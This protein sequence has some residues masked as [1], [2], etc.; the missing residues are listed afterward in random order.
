MFTVT[1]SPAPG[2]VGEVIGVPMIG[3]DDGG[4]ATVAIAGR[5]SKNERASAILLDIGD[6]VFSEYYDA[7]GKMPL[8]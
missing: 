8:L 4:A 5:S 7:S 2:E 1:W 6:N 3:C